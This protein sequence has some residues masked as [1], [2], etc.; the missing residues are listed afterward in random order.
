[1]PTHTF[2][3]R[4]EEEYILLS[5][6]FTAISMRQQGEDTHLQDTLWKSQEWQRRYTNTAASLVTSLCRCH[7]SRSDPKGNIPFLFRKR[8]VS[9]FLVPTLPQ[10]LLTAVLF[11]CFLFL[12][13]HMHPTAQCN[14]CAQSLWAI[15]RLQEIRNRGKGGENCRSRCDFGR[16]LAVQQSSRLF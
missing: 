15:K 10:P 13:L 2:T 16:R 5:S 1:M 6:A 8:K 4:E 14:N 9:L 3:E 11:F 7:V 12:H